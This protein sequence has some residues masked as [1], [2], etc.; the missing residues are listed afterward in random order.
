MITSFEYHGPESNPWSFSRTTLNRVNLF[1]GISGSGKTRFLNALFNIAR[2]VTL[3]KSLVETQGKPFEGGWK[4]SAGVDNYQYYW[5]CHTTASEDGIIINSEILKRITDNSI[6]ELL[7]ERNIEIIIFLGNN[8][9]KLDKEV[10]SINLLKNESSIAPFYRMFAQGLRRSFQDTALNNSSS[11]DTL[12]ISFVDRFKKIPKLENLFKH[13]FTVSSRLFFFQECFKNKYEIVENL[14]KN[15]FPTI[16]EIKIDLYKEIPG[17]LMPILYIK[18]RGVS[19][20]IPITELSSGMQ[21]VFLIITDILTMPG[22]CFYIMDEYENSLGINAINFLP[23]F[24][25][26]YGADNQFF[27]STHH[28]Y[29]V[30]NMPIKNWVLLNRNGSNVSASYG[31]SLEEKY[32]KSKQQAFI[33]LI[34]DPL[35]LEG[36]K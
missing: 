33:K 28:P 18:E 24:I 34:N 8:L 22:N 23:S 29:L 35:Y 10:C 13:D 6:E 12:K 31:S 21:K 9:P 16:K 19:K 27:I 14:I 26:E 36:V 32:G 7:I 15:I 3:G 4:M 30:N 20:W 25:E 1:V 17:T 5:E 2:M 11:F